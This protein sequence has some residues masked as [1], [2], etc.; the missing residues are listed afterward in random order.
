MLSDNPELA[1]VRSLTAISSCVLIAMGGIGEILTLV[2]LTGLNM[3][4]GIIAWGIA[5]GAGVIGLVARS[6]NNVS[7][8]H[9]FQISL[10]VVLAAQFIRLVIETSDVEEL[11]TQFIVVAILTVVTGFS[12]YTTKKY[13][14]ILRNEPE[15][16]T[17]Y[18][19]LSH[20]LLIRHR[21]SSRSSHTQKSNHSR[22]SSHSRNT[23]ADLQSSI[24]FYSYS[25]IFYH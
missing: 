4:F 21:T 1:K 14:Q 17:H 20:E 3:F 7:A 5:S 2:S 12:I 11:N 8:V 16:P 24:F 18:V 23:G 13:L 22:R 19:N 15:L 25:N 6:M 9:N 10:F